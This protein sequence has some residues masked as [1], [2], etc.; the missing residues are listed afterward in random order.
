V[1]LVLDTLQ[2]SSIV[3]IRKMLIGNSWNTTAKMCELTGTCF[4]LCGP[5][6]YSEHG[7]LI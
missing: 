4:V 3:A 1:A 2:K 5:C 7:V 6:K